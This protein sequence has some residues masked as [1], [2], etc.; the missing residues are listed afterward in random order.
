M[1][2]NVCLCPVTGV[3]TRK[4]NV[5]AMS[6]LSRESKSSAPIISQLIASQII[7]NDTLIF[8]FIDIIHYTLFSYELLVI[9]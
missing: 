6:Y 3:V 9:T 5:C 1:E 7:K 2:V 4:Q 8:F